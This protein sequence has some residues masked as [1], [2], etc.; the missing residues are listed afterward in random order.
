MSLSGPD[1]GLG[2][3]G[4]SGA[5]QRPAPGIRY[6]PAFLTDDEAND[7]LGVL[8]A[9]IPWQ[10]HRIQLFGRE[11]EEPRLTSWH[12]SPEASYRYSGRTRKPL[13]M[14]PGLTAVRRRLNQILGVDFNGVLLN[15][16][17]DGSDSMGWHSDDEPELGPEPQIASISL[18]AERRFLLRERA[19][20]QKVAE[21]W[22]QHGSL[23]LMSG[24]SQSTYQHAVPKTT[25][26][27]AE[28]INLTFRN[29]ITGRE[30]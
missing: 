16:Y 2:T 5:W 25:K 27:V 18:G 4:G 10:Q 9:I 28:R 24:H 19:S 7:A 22:L 20:H 15:R 14:T 13:P 11:V 12:G 30:K 29:V 8:M 3:S 17:R 21:L 26:P 6:L 1:G 23:L